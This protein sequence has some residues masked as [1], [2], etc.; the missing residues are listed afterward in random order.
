MKPVRVAIL[1]NREDS[2]VRPM[3]EGLERMVARAGGEPVLLPDGL[4]A[5]GRLGEQNIRT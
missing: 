2:F 4:E 3:A 1:G 5:L